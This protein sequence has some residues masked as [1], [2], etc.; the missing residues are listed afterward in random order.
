MGEGSKGLTYKFQGDLIQSIAVL[1]AMKLV[2]KIKERRKQERE[3]E[4]RR[5]LDNGALE[6]WEKMRQDQRLQ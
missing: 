4:V 3:G 2:H 1:K 5:C 6:W